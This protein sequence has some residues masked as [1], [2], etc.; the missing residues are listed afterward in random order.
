MIG[1]DTNLLVRY[2]VQDDPAQSKIAVDVLERK[3]GHDNSGF[4]N[5]IVLCELA[6]VLK[7]AYSYE[8]DKVIQTL[9]RLLDSRELVFENAG[10]ARLALAAFEKGNADFSDYLIGFINRNNG[11]SFTLTLDRKAAGSLQFKLAE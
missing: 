8:K 3:I 9:K 5:Q 2:I 7:R 6:W 10:C 4:V 11:C 1:I